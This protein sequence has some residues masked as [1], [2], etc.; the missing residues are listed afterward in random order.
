M[1]CRDKEAVTQQLNEAIMQG[2]LLAVQRPLLLALG[3]AW[4]T[5]LC[6]SKQASV[7]LSSEREELG[8]QPEVAAGQLAGISL[9]EVWRPILTGFFSMR[10]ML[11]WEL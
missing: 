1:C 7:H 11:L 4:L 8:R 10:V 2:R 9:A 6:L 3:A 5:L